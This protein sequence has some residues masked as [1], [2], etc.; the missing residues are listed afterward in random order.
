M[1]KLGKNIKKT[2][3]IC[4]GVLAIMVLINC[5]Q[6][7]CDEKM[8]KDIQEYKKRLAENFEKSNDVY[9]MAEENMKALS[10]SMNRVMS[11]IEK[12]P[13]IIEE[14]KNYDWRKL[15]KRY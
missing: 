12:H 6:N 9:A 8:E 2:I 14:L 13:E 11:C 3:I 15:N 5:G 1:K 4:A 7:A 10:K